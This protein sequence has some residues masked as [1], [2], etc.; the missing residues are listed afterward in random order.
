MFTA[1]L[2][3]NDT[4]DTVCILDGV[5]Q[6]KFINCGPTVGYTEDNDEMPTVHDRQQ[7]EGSNTLQWK[8]HLTVYKPALGYGMLCGTKETK[9]IMNYEKWQLFS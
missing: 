8:C 4:L 9:L 1:D 3:I 6:Q 7:E 5:T 2:Y